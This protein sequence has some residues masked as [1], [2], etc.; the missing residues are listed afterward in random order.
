MKVKNLLRRVLFV[1]L[2]SMFIDYTGE[3]KQVCAANAR[4]EV[5]R[6]AAGQVGYH[7]KASLDDLDDFTANSGDKNY[8]KYARDLGVANGYGWGA[9]FVWWVMRNAC[10]PIGAYPDR[11]TATRDFF[12]EKGQWRDREGYVPKSGDYVC[13]KNVSNCGIVESATED[14]VTVI[15][16]NRGETNAVTRDTISLDDTIILGYGLIDYEYEREPVFDNLGDV[17]C[18]FIAKSDCGKVI[19]NTGED[20]VLMDRLGNIR[21]EWAFFRQ[22]D[23]SYVIKSLADGSVLEVEDGEAVNCA[24]VNVG[25]E[26]GE[27]NQKWFISPTTWDYHLIPGHAT[28]F[29]LDSIHSED[30]QNGYSMKIYYEG[31]GNTKAY[32]IVKSLE[33]IFLSNTYLKEMTV[34][35]EQ[36]LSYTVAPQD[37]TANDIIWISSNPDIAEVNENGVVTAKAAGEVTICCAAKYAETIS[38]KVSIRIR[39]KE[40]PGTENP[41]ME[42]PKNEVPIEEIPVKDEPVTEEIPITEEMTTKEQSTEQVVKK[43]YKIKDKNF[44]YEVTSV[45]SK[46]VKITAVRSKKK[47]IIHIPGKVKYN[48]KT[49]K[50]TEIAKKA[51]K[52]NKKVKKVVIGNY[53]KRIGDD[54]FYGCSNLKTVEIGKSVVVIGTKSFYACKK[55]SRIYI[56]SSKLKKVG[57][58]AFKKLDRKPTIY[59]PRKKLKAYQRLFKGKI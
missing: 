8:T 49:Y 37:M 47:T 45:K 29:S 30:N 17:F 28:S 14:T 27:E 55:L 13:F 7:E 56:R 32:V 54:A 57:K 42:E 53:V 23:G 25:I 38:D 22:N 50:V 36:T 2:V 10:A 51:F 11:V 26:N 9:S 20:V 16:G 44:A 19:H 41:A 12:L 6:V 59:A 24:N 31:G 58:S 46:T 15:A 34:G 18:G 52:N 21:D 35:E 33:D 40:E 1:V 39:E 5:V 43:G 48:N 3:M 4:E